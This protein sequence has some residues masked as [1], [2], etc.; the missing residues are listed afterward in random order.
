MNN[1]VRPFGALGVDATPLPRMVASSTLIDFED[2][3]A[4]RVF[5]QALA[6]NFSPR[7]DR[8]FAQIFLIERT[9]GRILTR[10]ACQAKQ[11]SQ[12]PTPM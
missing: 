5:I 11:N 10:L 1:K 4:M 6:Y 8:E 12:H 7:N 3:D 2:V 9:G